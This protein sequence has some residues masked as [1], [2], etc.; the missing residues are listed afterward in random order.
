V[1][2]PSWRELLEL[3]LLVLLV[4]NVESNLQAWAGP[5]NEFAPSLAESALGVGVAQ[6]QR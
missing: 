6:K 1:I 5:G 4:L 3:F 2:S